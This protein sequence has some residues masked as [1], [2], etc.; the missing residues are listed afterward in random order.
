M[1]NEKKNAKFIS[2]KPEFFQTVKN[3]RTTNSL[4]EKRAKY[5]GLVIFL[6]QSLLKSDAS[7]LRRS[8]ISPN[9]CFWGDIHSRDTQE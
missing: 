5:K 7:F 1:R 4:Q 8:I 6:T 9:A 2:G 3:Q